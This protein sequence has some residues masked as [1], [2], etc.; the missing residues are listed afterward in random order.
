MSQVYY[1]IARKAASRLAESAEYHEL[2]NLVDEELANGFLSESRDMYSTP[3][4]LMMAAGLLL[5]TVQAAWQIYQ[6]LKQRQIEPKKKLMEQ[7]I[8]GE[9][10]QRAPEVPREELTQIIHVVVETTIYIGKAQEK[11]ESNR[12]AS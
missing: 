5:S 4:V 6:Y 11:V 1:K 3:E 7:E 9:M 10:E 8:S 12:E 2:P